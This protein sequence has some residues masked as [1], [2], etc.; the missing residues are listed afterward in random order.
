MAG[1][2]GTLDADSWSAVAE[3]PPGHL[4]V[5]AVVLHALWDSWVHERDIMVPLGLEPT[6]ESDEVRDCLLYIAALGP[7]YLAVQG[8]TRT[9]SYAV[10]AGEVPPFVVDIGP[11]VAVRSGP[12]PPGATALVG[13]AVDLIEALSFRGPPVDVPPADRWM[14]EG[15]GRMFD[16]G[17][18]G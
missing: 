5:P 16:V 17:D 15:L 18:A 4:P 13:T 8:S 9:G 6:P 7:T 11:E 14:M 1:A 12:V 3:A 10:E 2:I